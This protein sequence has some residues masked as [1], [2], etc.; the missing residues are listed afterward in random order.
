MINLT[1]NKHFIILA[2][3]GSH[4]GILLKSITTPLKL[5][6]I[7]TKLHYNGVNKV[8][9]ELNDTLSKYGYQYLWSEPISLGNTRKT[10]LLFVINNKKSGQI[11]DPDTIEEFKRFILNCSFKIGQIL[12]QEI[13]HVDSD[14]E[15]EY[16]FSKFYLNFI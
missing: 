5:T 9:S 10:R 7:A 6:G 14:G 2:S 3:I 16:A 13:E 15:I 8:S 1:S 12:N 4:Y 11:T